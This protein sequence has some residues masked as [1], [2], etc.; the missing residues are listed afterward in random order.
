MSAKAKTEQELVLTINFHGIGRPSR[1]LE[2]GEA[3]VWVSEDA[4]H[5]ILDLVEGRS[6]VEI[7]CDDG[8]ES[9]LNLLAPALAMRGLRCTFFL[10]AGRIDQPGSLSSAGITE[11]V[12]MGMG[13]GLHGFDH[14]SWR[15]LGAQAARREWIEARAVIEGTSSTS[16]VEAACPFGEYGRSTIA[17]LRRSGFVRVFT[18]DGG[19]S[20][21]Q[22]LVRSRNSVGRNLDAPKVGLLLQDP[23]VSLGQGVRRFLKR[24]R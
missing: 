12:R 15:G 16:L 18:S 2:V 17:G 19:W 22:G 23:R 21:R 24:C 3:D 11:L 4:M 13:I 1:E 20:H 14:V 7:T 10:L 6:D 9:D 8:N 5:S